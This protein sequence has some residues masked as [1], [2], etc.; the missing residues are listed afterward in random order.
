MTPDIWNSI[1]KGGIIFLLCFNIY[2]YL[3][4]D[5]FS[6]AAVDRMMKH[7]NDQARIMATE[8][9]GKMNEITTAAVAAGVLKAVSEIRELAPVTKELKRKM[10]A[11]KEKEA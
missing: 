9:I 3:H 1:E 8:I 11:E 4:G 2:L 10:K 7:G 6:K 5:I